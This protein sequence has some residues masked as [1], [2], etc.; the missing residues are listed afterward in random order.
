MSTLCRFFLISVK[1]FLHKCQQGVCRLS[2]MDEIF[3]VCERS[4]TERKYDN[5]TNSIW[6]EKG[7]RYHSDKKMFLH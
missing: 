1:V 4:L 3:S 2:I 6:G 7:N 5:E